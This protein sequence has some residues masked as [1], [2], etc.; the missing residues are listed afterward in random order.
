MDEIKKTI[1]NEI[2]KLFIK[3]T[4]PQP[5]LKR[6]LSFNIPSREGKDAVL[7]RIKGCVLWKCGKGISGRNKKTISNEIM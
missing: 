5:P 3:R 1:S 4:H 7:F 2:M 6:G